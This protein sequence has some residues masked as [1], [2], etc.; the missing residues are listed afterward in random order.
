V[1]GNPDAPIK[2]VEYASHTCPHCADFAAEAATPLRD[3]Y[4]AGGVVSYEIRNQIHEP[5]DLTIAMLAR[6]NGPASFQPMAEQ[7]WANL[8]TIVQRI[9]AGGKA[10]DAAGKAPEAQRWRE[11]AKASGLIDFFAAHGLPAAKAN[12]CLT[13]PAAKAIFDRSEQQSDQLNVSGT[14][15]FFINGR[16]VELSNDPVWPQIEA[17]L[18][19]AGAR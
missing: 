8:D 1:V 19:N 13:D 16:L 18:H 11:I 4:V 7:V 5:F 6:C 10:L 15:T 14:P 2:L 9:K 3:K 17:A 12:Q